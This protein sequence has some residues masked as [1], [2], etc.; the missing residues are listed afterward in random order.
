VLPRMC[1]GMVG[2]TTNL[3]GTT[4]MKDIIKQLTTSRDEHARRADTPPLL[5]QGFIL[6]SKTD[7]ALVVHATGQLRPTAAH[8]CGVPHRGI[9]HA[10]TV[11][12]EINAKNAEKVKPM[13][14]IFWHRM[15][16]RD[17][18]GTITALA[19]ASVKED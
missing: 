18:T 15:M 4:D 8:L 10:E 7:P 17:I 1:A 5:G 2:R 6:V 12:A 19:A 11:A 16:V 13:H 9:A 14:V 3:K